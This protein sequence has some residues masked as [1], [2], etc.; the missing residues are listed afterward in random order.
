MPQVTVQ[1]LPVQQVLPA[2]QVQRGCLGHWAK[3]A[4]M[5]RTASRAHKVRQVLLVRQV[6]QEQLGVLARTV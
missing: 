4:S 6:L 5:D 1:P 2:L 3:T